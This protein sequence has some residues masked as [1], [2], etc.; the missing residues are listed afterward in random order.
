MSSKI[1][2]LTEQQCLSQASAVDFWCFSSDQLET[3]TERE[4]QISGYFFDRIFV[5]RFFFF[6]GYKFVYFFI[7][8]C[9]FKLQLSKKYQSIFFFFF[10]RKLMNIEFHVL[11]I[12]DN[13]VKYRRLS[14]ILN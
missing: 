9:K 6:S 14:G 10:F 2:I 13:T 11:I 1:P 8:R 12:S 4:S 5:L 7:F 3:R